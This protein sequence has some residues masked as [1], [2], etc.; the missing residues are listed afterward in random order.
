[1]NKKPKDAM[2]IGLSAEAIVLEKLISFGIKARPAKGHS[3]FDLELLD[4]RKIEVK[5][6]VSTC[7]TTSDGRP[8]YR[9]I[10]RRPKQELDRADFFILMINDDF[11]VIPTVYLSTSS[12]LA[13]PWPSGHMKRSK[14]ASFHNR[15]DLLKKQKTGDK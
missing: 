3:P 15:F 1:M 11:F 12:S 2:K 8:L 10:I 5:T 7:E 13:I 6:R 4:G 9:F 14:W